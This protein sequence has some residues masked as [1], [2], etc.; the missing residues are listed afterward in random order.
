MVATTETLDNVEALTGII[1]QK[2]RAEIH[3]DDASV[4]RNQDQSD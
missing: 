4:A 2:G 1:N 3:T